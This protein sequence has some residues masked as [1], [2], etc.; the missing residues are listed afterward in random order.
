MSRGRSGIVLTGIFVLALFMGPGPG[1]H[2]VNPDPTDPEALRTV[3]GLPIVY[4]WGVLWF[5]VEAAVLIV[6]Y[7]TVW[8]GDDET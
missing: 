8:S 1:L 7:F 5:G 3:L 2:L 6:A 4:A